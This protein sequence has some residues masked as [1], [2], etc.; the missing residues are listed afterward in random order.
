MKFSLLCTESTRFS[1][2]LKLL[3][4]A[5]TQQLGYRVLR[6]RKLSTRRVQLRYGHS[7]N[8]IAQY[9]WFASQGLSTLEFTQS[10]EM[11]QAWLANGKVVFGRKFLNSSCGKGIV[12][13]EKP[14]D[15]QQCPVYT[16]YKKKK[17]EFR[18][19]G[20]KKLILLKR[21]NYDLCVH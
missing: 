6:T 9:V 11:A 10:S 20:Y 4:G 15:F 16:V 7:V 5:L 2:S 18:A 1:A 19:E 17:R 12:I 21:R 13:M 3:A 8:K 14:E